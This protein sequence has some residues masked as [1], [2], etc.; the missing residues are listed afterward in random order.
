MCT[1]NPESQLQNRR[2][3]F[4]DPCEY[5]LVQNLHTCAPSWCIRAAWGR[6]PGLSVQGSGFS[7]QGLL[8]VGPPSSSA[9][10]HTRQQEGIALFQTA[11]GCGINLWRNI[12]FK[13]EYLQKLTFCTNALNRTSPF[14]YSGVGMNVADDDYSVPESSSGAG[15]GECCWLLHI[16]VSNID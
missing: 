6:S 15:L 16:P 2:S 13:L 12:E 10:N 4:R 8:H 11:L 14:V 3:S 5:L 9:K 1:A 7:I